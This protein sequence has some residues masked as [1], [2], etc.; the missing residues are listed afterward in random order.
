MK[1]KNDCFSIF[2]VLNDLGS[3]DI[4]YSFDYLNPNN[5]VL[6][7]KTIRI[8]DV[9]TKGSSKNPNTIAQQAKGR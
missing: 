5:F 6:V 8:T 9:I 1:V 4:S 2:K 7:G 3:E